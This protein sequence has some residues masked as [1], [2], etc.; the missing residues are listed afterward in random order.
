MKKIMEKHGPGHPMR[1][2]AVFA[3]V[4]MAVCGIAIATGEGIEAAEEKE[5]TG[6]YTSTYDWNDEVA[7]V[8]GCNMHQHP[9]DV[10]I[11]ETTE[12]DDI[13]NL[14]THFP[15]RPSRTLTSSTI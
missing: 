7:I 9:T 8:T 10:K 14:A 5:V 4:M 1:G 15:Q 2:F 6:D 3:A 11:P 12:K 13:A